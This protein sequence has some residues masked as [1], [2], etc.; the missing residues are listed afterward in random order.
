MP[1][2]IRLQ[3]IAKTFLV[4][5]L[6]FCLQY[7]IAQTK[8]GLVAGAG[9]SSLYKFPVPPQDFDGYSSQ[10]AWWIGLKTTVPLVKNNLDLVI[11]STFN[12]KGYKYSYLKE[13]GTNNT[14]K[15]SSF[16]QSLNYV[17]I[18]F[19]FRK[20]FMF[21]EESANSFFLG[22]GPVLN[23]FAG[24]KEKI[25]SSYFGNMVPAVNK[26]NSSLTTGS[27]PGQYA[28]WFLGWGFTLGF[29]VNKFSVWLNANIPFGTY[30]QDSQNDNDH[31]IKTFG[32]NAG[33]TLFTHQKKEREKKE[34]KE[35][36]P[37][38]KHEDKPVVNIVPD[39]LVDTDGDGII[40]KNDKCPTVKGTSKYNGC[41]IPDTDGDGIN[42]EIDKCITIPGTAANN[43]CPADTNKTVK[44]DTSCFLVYFEPGKSILRSEAYASLTEVVK[45]LK[46]NPKLIAVFTGHTDNV[47]SEA[48]NYNRSLL[49]ASVCADY[50]ASFYIDRKRLTIVS[51]GNKMP[52]A[53]LNDPLLQWKNRRVEICVFEIK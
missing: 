11:M 27:G 15:D 46:A 19:N 30:Y 4:T 35:R 37:K 21:D 29:E 3:Y 2:T 25:A 34:R 49:R 22:T 31:K 7:A 32:I 41:P 17:D 44:A 43:G 1:Q 5:L 39:S 26:T 47:G 36:K 24:G 45:L 48:A 10:G 28:P 50:V 16:K 9:K 52:A 8:Y 38:I 13:T 51:M 53:D 40:D 23:F 18:N 6:L 14:L 33:Y 12:S 20:K 42:D